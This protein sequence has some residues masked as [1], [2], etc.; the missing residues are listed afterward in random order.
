MGGPRRWTRE[1][2]LSRLF[3]ARE[4]RPRNP[5]IPIPPP[6]PRRRWRAAEQRDLGGE[7]PAR[8]APP[9]APRK[10]ASSSKK[11]SQQQASQPS[12][13]GIQHFFERYSQSVAAA[14]ASSQDAASPTAPAEVCLSW[15]AA[16]DDDADPP[17]VSPPVAK[18]APLKRFKF[19]PG[20]VGCGPR[21]FCFDGILEFELVKK[22]DSFSPFFD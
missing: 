19:S 9:M 3:K 21:I 6:P 11:P 22:F 7:E 20:M 12:K 8:R 17:E 13:F 18:A 15:Q 4:N 5:Q 1:K 14:G 10:R 2:G 16:G